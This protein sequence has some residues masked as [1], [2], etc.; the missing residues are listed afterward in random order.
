MRPL[1]LVPKSRRL[2]FTDYT[3]NR[4]TQLSSTSANSVKVEKPDMT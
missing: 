3:M 4:S 1:S 2:P